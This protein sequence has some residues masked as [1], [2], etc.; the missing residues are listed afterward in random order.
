MWGGSSGRTRPKVVAD[1]LAEF[2]ADDVVT[3]AL[4][5]P[6]GADRAEKFLERRPA[7]IPVVIDPSGKFCDALGIYKRPVNVVIDRHGAVRFAGLNKRGLPQ[8]VAELVAEPFDPG[9]LPPT[10]P[11]GGEFPQFSTPIKRTESWLG[12]GLPSGAPSPARRCR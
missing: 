1:S 5:T 9:V 8:A 2:S 7:P 10:P 4:H 6:E 3:L 12:L 11:E